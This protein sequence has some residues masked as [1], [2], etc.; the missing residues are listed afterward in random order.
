MTVFL[1]VL[2]LIVCFILV[3]VVLLQTGKGAEIG[4]T[5]GGSSNTLF[6]S[7]GAGTFLSKVTAAAAAL[8]MLTSLFLALKWSGVSSSSIVKEPTK[9][10]APAHSNEPG[11]LPAKPEH[12]GGLPTVP[13]APGPAQP[14][15]PAPQGGK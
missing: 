9:Q 10:E 11:G 6:G 12:A 8:F 14:A 5:F 1:L 15:F 2:H 13:G 4:A 3:M 7:R